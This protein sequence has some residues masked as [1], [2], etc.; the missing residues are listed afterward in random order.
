MSQGP[1][2]GRKF[3]ASGAN[4]VATSYPADPT[5]PPSGAT[6]TVFNVGTANRVRVYGRYVLGAAGTATVITLK[7]Q[8]RYNDP[9][10]SV[11]YGWLDLATQSEIA[12]R[13]IAIDQATNLSAG[14]NDFGFVIDQ[15]KGLSDCIL[16]AK[17]TTGA[18][19]ANDSLNV[20][21]VAC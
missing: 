11:T 5:S 19:G 15:P 20:Y 6:A 1:Y 21:V 18:M 16:L 12:A 7:V 2:L 17:T 13:T 10:G 9:S 3:T 8:Y 14:N 4:A